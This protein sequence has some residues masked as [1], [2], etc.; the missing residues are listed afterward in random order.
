MA[1]HLPVEGGRDESEGE[2]C[3]PE[4]T[5]NNRQHVGRMAIIHFL[6]SVALIKLM[7]VC[8]MLGLDE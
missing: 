4:P 3:L 7:M 2:S 5:N 8:A 6:P 1:T